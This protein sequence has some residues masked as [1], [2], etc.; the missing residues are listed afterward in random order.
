MLE[1]YRAH[2][3]PDSRTRSKISVHLIAQ[4]SAEDI[5]A[6]IDP[7]EQL[8]KLTASVTDVLD[9]LGLEI[10]QTALSSQLEK[11]DLG[12][13]DAKSITS[14]VGTYLKNTA[15]VAVEQ[16]EKLLQPAEQALASFLPSL[17]IKPQADNTEAVD[18]VGDDV[19][20]EKNKPV[21]IKDVKAFKASLPLSAGPRPVKDPT[22]FEDLE[23][24][25]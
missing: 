4:A 24:K 14:T 5:A 13:S 9:Q 6:K 8:E 18:E 15:G 16:V 20:G 23:S 1:F 21:L 2:F 25:L 12:T 7:K 22:E 11:L 10:D 19:V 17:G 3:S